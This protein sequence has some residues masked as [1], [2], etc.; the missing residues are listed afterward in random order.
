MRP[1]R[2]CL[3]IVLHAAWFHPSMVSCISLPSLLILHDGAQSAAKIMPSRRGSDIR[4]IEYKLTG[5]VS[6]D[7]GNQEI[8]SVSIAAACRPYGANVL[9]F[10]V[11]LTC[12]RDTDIPSAQVSTNAAIG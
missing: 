7:Y 3:E 5:S 1:S 10:A 6:L 4:R 12:Y 11:N 9:P 2:Y 8:V